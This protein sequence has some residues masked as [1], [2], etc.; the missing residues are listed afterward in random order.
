MKTIKLTA[1]IA[2]LCILAFKSKAQSSFDFQYG[3]LNVL[4]PNAL[5]YAVQQQNIE[6]TDEGGGISY[7]NPI[8]NGTPAILTQ[9]F[10]FSAPTTEIFLSAD[11]AA[12]NFG[13]SDYGSGSLWAS[14]DGINWVELLNAPTPSSGGF[15]YIYDGNLPSSLLGANQI[16]IQAQ[17][18]TSGE[19]ILAQFE[20]EGGGNL[21]P[22]A[23]D[24]NVVPENSTMSLFGVGLAILA[25]AS[26]GIKK[27]VA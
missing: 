13:G 12:F 22:F 16:Y 6:T 15:G 23:L 18:E 2:G 9:E 25:F 27:S 8:N 21:P 5:N 26:K 14:P 7:M 1:L 20:R 19:D 10:T 4:S 11:I 24:A 3:Y 17:L